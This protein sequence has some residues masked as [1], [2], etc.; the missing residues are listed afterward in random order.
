[1]TRSRMHPPHDC[2]IPQ[3]AGA[4]A[5]DLSNIIIAGSKEYSAELLPNPG[6]WVIL[7]MQVSRSSYF[8]C[9]MPAQNSLPA[10]KTNVHIDTRIE[11]LGDILLS[12]MISRRL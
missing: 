10:S 5:V 11:F 1:M 8:S 4:F 2:L 6:V 9:K 12:G 3:I 7:W